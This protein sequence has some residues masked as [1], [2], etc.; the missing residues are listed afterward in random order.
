MGG[1]F[2]GQVF[3]GPAR[4][5]TLDV[6]LKEKRLA[7]TYGASSPAEITVPLTQPHAVHDYI[8]EGKRYA[9]ATTEDSLTNFDVD[10]LIA[11]FI[12]SAHKPSDFPVINRPLRRFLTLGRVRK[13]RARSPGIAAHLH[14]YTHAV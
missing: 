3:Y 14:Q 8:C 9:I 6:P 2:H 12:P 1:N 4:Q 5:S 11:E 7:K 10:V 13:L